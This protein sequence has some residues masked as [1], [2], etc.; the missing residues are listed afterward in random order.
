MLACQ[1]ALGTPKFH[2]GWTECSLYTYV[3]HVMTTSLPLIV[4]V[5]VSVNVN[6]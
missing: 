1:L 4:D 5:M 2:R 6:V 3:H